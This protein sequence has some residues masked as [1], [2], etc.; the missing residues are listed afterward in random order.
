MKF[1][2]QFIGKV[3]ENHQQ[4]A[5]ILSVAAFPLKKKKWLEYLGNRDSRAC[6]A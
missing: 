6:K 2:F 4:L 3:F 1:Q 5:Y